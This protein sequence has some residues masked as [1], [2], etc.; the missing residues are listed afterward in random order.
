[1]YCTSEQMID[2]FGLSVLVQLTNRD[3]P[4]AEEINPLALDAAI[5]DA[6]AEINMHLAGRYVLPL[7]TVP[8]PI[9]RIA[10]VLTRDILAGSTDSSDERWQDQAKSSRQT[11]KDIAAGRMSLGVDAAATPA[12]PESGVQ[13]ES[14]GRVWSRDSSKGF[15]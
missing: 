2:R 3:T 14:G 9:V 11:L 4:G 6:T 15:L 5:A 12:A 1:M 7:S 8:L 13:V 10:C